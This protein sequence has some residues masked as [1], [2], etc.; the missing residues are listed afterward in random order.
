[1][2][3]SGN[4]KHT[5]RGLLDFFPLAILL[6]V[7][8]CFGLAYLV[9]LGALASYLT[10]ELARPLGSELR[11]FWTV[12]VPGACAISALLGLTAVA[13]RRS[14][15]RGGL[16]VSGQIVA[17]AVLGGLA[18]Y[19]GLFALHATRAGRAPSL[20]QTQQVA[21]R[22]HPRRSGNVFLPTEWHALAALQ[23][24]GAPLGPLRAD[25]VGL[26]GHPGIIPRD[27][28]LL[29]R[30]TFVG[31]TAAHVETLLGPGSRP[32]A[33]PETLEYVMFPAPP[34]YQEPRL[35]LRSAPRARDGRPVVTN[36]TLWLEADFRRP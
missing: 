24:Q 35:R 5:G 18:F 1:M 20:P 14:L 27:L 34:G 11:R 19:A 8:A 16:V 7:A 30:V 13:L 29:Q 32:T 15:R 6:A 25:G 21:Q 22:A 31:L 33:L 36:E 17:T 28:H 3:T 10:D 23:R 2:E 4:M 26:A 12:N 9:T